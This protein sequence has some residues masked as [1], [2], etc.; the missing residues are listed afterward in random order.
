MVFAETHAKM[1]SLIS[2]FYH[3]A[4]CF[5]HIKCN[6]NVHTMISSTELSMACDSEFH[7]ISGSHYWCF[8]FKKAAS[9]SMEQQILQF[10]QCIN[11]CSMCV[12]VCVRVCVCVCVYK[13][14][15]WKN[16]VTSVLYFFIK[17]LTVSL[18]YWFRTFISIVI[19]FS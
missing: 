17:R 19:E 7:H 14:W 8:F 3:R 13:I 15:S 9:T 2:M 11:N 18:I 4:T 12:N 5:K 6:F 1:S 10:L 16:F